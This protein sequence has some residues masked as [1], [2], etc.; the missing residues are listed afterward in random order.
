MIPGSQVDCGSESLDLCNGELSGLRWYVAQTRSRHEKS[1]A[2]Y[3]RGK[4]EYLLPLYHTVHRWKDRTTEV[5]LP[6]FPGYIFVRIR[7]ADRLKVLETPGVQR[8]VQFGGIPVPLRE[9]ELRAVRA[10]DGSGAVIQPHPF[11]K[12]GKRVRV[13]RGPFV[14]TEGIVERWA[15]PFRVVLSIEM[16]MRSVV[17]EMDECDLSPVGGSA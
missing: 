13:T 7:I 17:L 16:I 3:L 6:L 1:A 5:Q 10:C 8:L 2:Q 15:K 9:D 14:N 4:C 12:K 11:L